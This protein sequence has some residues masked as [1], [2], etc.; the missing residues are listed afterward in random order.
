MAR[1]SVI[2]KP[3]VASLRA[4]NARLAAENTELK[5]RMSKNTVVSTAKRHHFW[6]SFTVIASLSIAGAVLVAGNLLFWAGNT[7][8]DTNKFISTTSPL[9]KEPAI[10]QGVALYA[11]NQLYQGVDIEQTIQDALPPKAEFLAPT[12]SGQV[13]QVTQTSL[14]KVLANEKFQDLWTTTV[15]TAHSKIINYAKNYEGN[16]TITL[17]DMYQNLSKE[18]ENTKLSFAAN[19]T[20]PSNIGNITVINAGWLPTVHN[21]VVNIGL[22]QALTTLFFIALSGLAVWLSQNRRRT[23]ITLGILYGALM[24][25]TLMS[26][27]LFQNLLPNKVDSQYQP[28][29]SAA[30]KTITNPLI[31]QTRTILLLGLLV[32][33]IAWITA[34]YPAAR[35]VRGRIQILL[36]GKLHKAVFNKENAFTLWVGKNR[37]VLQWVSVSIIAAIMLIVQLSPGL[38]AIYA[39]VIL[40]AVLVIEFLSAPQPQLARKTS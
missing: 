6:K 1:K 31:I 8:V 5:N 4:E 27:R 12:L 36:E 3:T 29:V 9:I 22:Y 13:K 11:T 24:A 28:A 10:Q 39:L 30:V 7:L 20:L 40:A 34:K 18:L 21:I 33:V 15:S 16:G 17:S 32:V 26:V 38:V 19:R 14:E 37:R 23:V 25:L 2:T 35:A